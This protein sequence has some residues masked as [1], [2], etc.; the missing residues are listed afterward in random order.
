MSYIND[1]SIK[2]NYN[3]AKENGIFNGDDDYV[4]YILINNDLNM[5]Y[6]KILNFCCQSVYKVVKAN[7]GFDCNNNG[8]IN[9]MATGEKICIIKAKEND[10]LYCINKYSDITDDVWCQNI[11]DLGNTDLSAFSLVCVAFTPM[12]KKN[13]PEFMKSLKEL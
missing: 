9:W 3:I 8:Y 6:G 12:I 10:L 2:I 5:D 4:L 7:E 11:L 1:D 13:I